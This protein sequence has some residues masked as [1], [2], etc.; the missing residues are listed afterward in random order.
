MVVI[1]NF[2]CAISSYRMGLPLNVTK[3]MFMS[4][5]SRAVLCSTMLSMPCMLFVLLL[6]IF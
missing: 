6:L 3:F 2:M 4:M 1:R 5:A